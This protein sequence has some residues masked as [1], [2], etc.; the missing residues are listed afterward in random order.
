MPEWLKGVVCKTT[1]HMIHV[2]SNP[3]IDSNKWPVGRIGYCTNLLSWRHCDTL[4]SNPRRVTKIC[5]CGEIGK[6]NPLK[7]DRLVLGGSSPLT[8]TNP[9]WRN[10]ETR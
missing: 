6:H 1:Y 5:V 4:G 3:T 10:W 7:T 2:G 9:L 8:R